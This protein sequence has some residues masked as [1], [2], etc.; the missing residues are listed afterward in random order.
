MFFMTIGD[1]AALADTPMTV[2][3]RAA[4]PKGATVERV[5]NAVEEYLARSSV[6]F[7]VRE[8]ALEDARSLLEAAF[9]RG[10][11]SQGL[12]YDL[13]QVYFAQKRYSLVLRELT[14]IASAPRDPS[15]SLA[16]VWD[17]LGMAYAHLEMHQEERD[18][19]REHL[20]VLRRD[21]S[22]AVATMN[23]AESEMALGHLDESIALYREAFRLASE[24]QSMSG[25]DA[26]ALSTWGLAVVLDRSGDP[27]AALVEATRANTLD[28]SAQ[29]LTKDSV[30]FAPAYERNWYLAL[31][32]E[33]TARS[34]PETSRER[35][36]VTAAA[37]FRDYVNKASEKGR[38]DRWIELAKKRAER[39]EKQ[40]EQ[41]KKL[42]L[43]K[44][45]P[46][47]IERLPVR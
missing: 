13:A 41:A 4:D 8:L 7:P 17:L 35:Y 25:G 12:H 1:A 11:D 23:L 27:G 15:I 9:A 28:P 22:R 16:Q 40:A 20:K 34:L 44:Q 32:A 46:K 42:R 37:Y 29:I 26:A 24:S 21:A 39:L 10:I 2:W 19:H 43:R 36:L 38:T 33:A 3:Q 30:F 6:K 18:A 14:P 47:G 5:H 31:S 45:T